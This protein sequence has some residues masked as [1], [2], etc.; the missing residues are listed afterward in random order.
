MKKNRKPISIIFL[1]VLFLPKPSHAEWIRLKSGEVIE[2]IVERI[3]EGDLFIALKDGESRKV[4]KGEVASIDFGPKKK[5][6]ILD[7]N[8]NKTEHFLNA[9][10]KK[11]S[12][13][14]TPLQTFQA[15][16]AAAVAGNIDQMVDCYAS[17]KQ[18]EIKKELKKIP[19]EKREQM[20]TTTAQT[21]F[22]PTEP[23]Y[24]GERA[25]LEVNWQYGLQGDSQTL[26]FILEKDQWKIIQ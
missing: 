25:V 26:Q 17:F 16:K 18:K 3:A 23:Y 1:S 5:E 20:K 11:D 13:Y 9:L 7:T 12:K 14:G 19:R 21:E 4:G 2:G 15:W 10:A 24:Q 6:P 22:V 8:E